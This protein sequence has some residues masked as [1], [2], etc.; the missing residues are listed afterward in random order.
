MTSRSMENQPDFSST[1]RTDDEID[2]R[3]VYGALRRRKSLIAKI[4]AATVLLTGIYAFTRKPVWQG[5]FEIVLAS[6]Q[7]PTSQASSLIQSN[8]GLANLIGAGGGNDQLETEVEILESPSV[9]K[10]VF[11]F[12]KQ[13][14]QQRGIDTQN[15]RYADWL[16]ENL[17]IELV[18]G[19]SV[20]EL[21]YKDT[22]K[23]LI[24]P[25]I[26]KISDAYQ[27]YSGRDRERGINQA[28]QYLDQQIKIYNQKS[29]R[30]LRT[31]QEYGIEQKLTALR[32]EGTNDAEIKNSLNIEAIRIAA[33]NQIR[34]INEQLKQL[35]KL[36]NS[37]ETL[38]YIGRNI[39]GLASQG[40]PQTL[41][42]LDTRLALLR[43][44]YTDQ[45]DSIRRLLEKRRLLVDVFKRQT[46]GYLYAQRS[47]AQARLKAAERPKGVLIKYRELLRTAARDEATLTKLESERQ[48]LALEQARKED[49]WE[50][51]SNPTLLDKPVA[52]RKKRM[53]A[54]GLFAGLVAGGGAALLVDRRTGLV[55]SEDELKNLMPCPLIK[56]LPAINGSAWTDT[57]DLL[58][59][60]PL[61]QSPG[62]GAIALIPIGKIPDE[63]LQ[64]FSAE[65]RRALGGRELLIS[66]D[67]R[68]TSRCATQLLL[69]SPGAATR[70]QLSQLRQKLALQ[71]TPLAGW[72]LLDP[73]LK[74]G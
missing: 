18:K 43:S 26:Q 40:L 56:H 27:D 36:D 31:A 61:A 50:L 4:T 34:N 20:L 49:P 13:Q 48:I 66:M 11:D 6:S 15:W 53:V 32:G 58:A 74:L 55:Y 8:P 70:T 16:K 9:L 57:A 68:Q 39:P 59:S 47:A 46:Y 17:T 21:A 51:I 63:Q 19:T 60:G 72:V 29:V 23:D 71:G 44:K 28:I 69:T 65:L 35:K 33:S 30:S 41:D 37:P 52:P 38:M 10:P 2:L 73:D 54:L 3:Q 5:Q 42:E 22:D 62:N 67:L 1:A 25:T 24:L 12:V 45:D 64:A 7:S 14:K